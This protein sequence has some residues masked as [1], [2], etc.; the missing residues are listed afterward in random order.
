MEGLSIAPGSSFTLTLTATQGPD[1]GGPVSSEVFINEFHY[2][3]SSTDEGEFIELVV[4]PGFASSGGDLN[5]IEVVLYNGNPTQLSPYDSI[6]L[7]AFDNFSSPTID[8][9]YQI[10]SHDIVLQNGPDGIAI[11]IDGAVTQFISY[12]DSFTPL[13]GPATGM[14]SFDIGVAQNPVFESGFGSVGLTG[15]GADSGSMSW[16]RFEET[17]AHTPGQANPGQTFTGSVPMPPQAFSF[18]NVTVCIL[19]PLDSDS[20]GDPDTSDPDDDN[21]QLPDLVEALLGTN[22]LLS[23]SDSNGILDGDEDSDGDGHTNL[24]EVLIT[25]TDP[26]A[27]SSAFQA[28]LGPHPTSANNLAL[29]FPTLAGRNYQILNGQDPSQLSPINTFVGT[30][31]PLTFTIFPS[32]SEAAFYVVAVSLSEE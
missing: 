22:P 17:I 7:S 32:Q 2:D 25:L 26:A 16:T 13:E 30:G 12:E 19:E 9:G 24:A 31:N 8:N 29:T 23:D 5:D 15:A 11:V 4:A 10:F 6:E 27:P 20:D 21:D 18:D 1:S 3:N 14:L 28:N